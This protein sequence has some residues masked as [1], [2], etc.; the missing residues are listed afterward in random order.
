MTDWAQDWATP[1][2][3]TIR[4]LLEARGLSE[5]ELATHLRLTAEQTAALLDGTSHLSERVAVALDSLFGGNREY[6]GLFW[7]VRETQYRCA[8]VLLSE[9]ARLTAEIERLTAER[10]AVIAL[11]KQWEESATYACESPASGCGCPGCSL[12]RERYGKGQD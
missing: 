4:D 6:P 1:P 2:G 10:D 8:L 5:A 3:A 9:R 12:A 7:I 11:A